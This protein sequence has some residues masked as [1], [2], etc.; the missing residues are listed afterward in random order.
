MR[1]CIAFGYSIAYSFISRHKTP[2]RNEPEASMASQYQPS[3]DDLKAAYRK[4]GLSLLG[5]GFDRA[6]TIKPICTAITCKAKAAHR[7]AG[8]NGKPAPIQ[9]GLI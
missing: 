2:R 4:T 5:I 9:P 3:T 1:L 8:N 7:A 6:M